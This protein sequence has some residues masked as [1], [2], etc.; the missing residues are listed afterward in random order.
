[1]RA[2]PDNAAVDAAAPPV[3]LRPGQRAERLATRA[4]HRLVPLRAQHRLRN[5]AAVLQYLDRA[6]ELALNF[7]SI[8]AIFKEV[9][10]TASN[11][12]VETFVRPGDLTL[13]AKTSRLTVQ[14]QAIR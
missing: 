6:C 8:E 11:F 10:M 5:S 7:V 14:Q 12:I 13:T 9:S 3:R 4:L 2:T 1:M